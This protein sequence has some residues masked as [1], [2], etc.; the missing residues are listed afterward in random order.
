M[1]FNSFH[2]DNDLVWTFSTMQMADVRDRGKGPGI[3]LCKKTNV[4]VCVSAIGNSLTCLR[5]CISN[6]NCL[7]S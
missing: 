3:L 6:H 2:L 7:G 1:H 4:V 5:A